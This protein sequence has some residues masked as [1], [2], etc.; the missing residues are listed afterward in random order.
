MVFMLMDNVRADQ[1]IVIAHR[2]ASGYLP[3]H[4]LAAKAMAYAFG[5]DYLEQDV[6]L[7]ADDQPIVLH[8]IHLDTVTNVAEVYPH[9]KRSDGRFYAIDFTLH[10]VR[11]LRVFER[12]DLQTGQAV[13]ARRFPTRTSKFEIP[14]LADEIEFVQGLNKSTGRQVG[15]YPEIKQPA[16]HRQSGKDI[17]HIVIETLSKY[18][19]VDHTDLAFLQCFDADECQRIRRDLAC[20]LKLIQL[21]SEDDWSPAVE[22]EALRRIAT[23][24]DGV[25]PPLSLV[26]DDQG[27]CTSFAHEARGDRLLVHPYTFRIDALPRPFVD[28]HHLM[29]ALFDD[30]RVDGLFTD[31]PD[32]T[33]KYLTDR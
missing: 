5:A 29:Q 27:R 23:Y 10:E 16:F 6:V 30:A 13:F 18:G 2:G 7:T 24:A 25:G 4:T 14:T 26:L 17:S 15:I 9:R 19:Y 12:I 32:V 11:Q 8:D 33:K 22:K 31:F 1:P 20:R 3:E 28:A 21:I